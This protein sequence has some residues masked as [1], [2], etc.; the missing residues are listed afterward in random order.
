MAYSTSSTAMAW[1]ADACGWARLDKGTLRPPGGPRDSAADPAED[2]GDERAVHALAHDVGQDGARGA[3]QR[4]GDDER[5]IAQREADAGGGPARIGI[6]HRD[7]DRHVG[8]AD[9]NDDQHADQERGERDQPECQIAFAAHEPDD[10]KNQERDQR[11]ID[12]VPQRQQDRPA[13][14]ASIDLGK[15]I[16][17]PVKVMAPM[18][19]PSDISTR[20]APWIAPTVPMPNASGA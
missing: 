7:D 14:H 1:A 17:D 5:G 3:D 20:L 16:T 9:R 11:Q 4:P 8:A 13:A 19:S 10:E 15:A 2:H 12:D 6:E 18:V